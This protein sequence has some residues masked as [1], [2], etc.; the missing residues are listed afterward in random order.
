MNRPLLIALALCFAAGAALAAAAKP[1]DYLATA[2]GRIHLG[3]NPL[4][5]IRGWSDGRDCK[6]RFQMKAPDG[7]VVRWTLDWKK[8]RTVQISTRR[9]FI[10]DV[11]EKT[12]QEQPGLILYG[13]QT[14]SATLPDGTDVKF[15]NIELFLKDP[16]KE[17]YAF[18]ALQAYAQACRAKR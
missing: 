6:S 8:V 9:H 15:D 12:Y 4:D 17:D 1:A 14:S 11:E 10:T 3:D 7:P 5:T 2:R 13:F 16:S 18:R